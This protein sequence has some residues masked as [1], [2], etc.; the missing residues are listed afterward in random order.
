MTFLKRSAAMIALAGM[1]LMPLSGVS[2][3]Y[4]HRHR[5]AVASQR[6]RDHR[7]HT[8]AKIVVGS[9]VGGAV[10]GGLLGGPKG[11]LIG[12]GVGA[13]GGAIANH[14]RVKKGVRAR[15]RREY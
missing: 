10:V 14:V 9:A 2:Q 7:H 3:S 5:R 12:A 4:A 8:G 15:E 13:G 11:A 1:T 6:A